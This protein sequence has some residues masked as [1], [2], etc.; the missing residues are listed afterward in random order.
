M[1]RERKIRLIAI[2]VTLVLA[3]LI[4]V[5]A[6][7]LL[8]RALLS[9]ARGGAPEGAGEEIWVAPTLAPSALFQDSEYDAPDGIPSDSAEQEPAEEMVTVPV[10]KSPEQL[11]MEDAEQPGAEEAEQDAQ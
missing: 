1:N 10:E 9:P 11:A 5:F 7:R 6:Y 4:T 2:A 8:R 3:L